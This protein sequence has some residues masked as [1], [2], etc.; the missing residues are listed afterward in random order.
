MLQI[1]NI[2][3]QPMLINRRQIESRQELDSVDKLEIKRFPLL[4]RN[5]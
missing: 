4:K 2:Q 1:L 5:Y 3:T